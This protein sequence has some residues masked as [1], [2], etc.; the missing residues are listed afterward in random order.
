MTI[1]R[2]PYTCTATHGTACI[3]T[4]KTTFTEKVHI[5][6]KL[7]YVPQCGTSVHQLVTQIFTLFFAFQKK[8]YNFSEI[9]IRNFLIRSDQSDGQRDMCAC[10]RVNN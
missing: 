2:G 4:K 9:S 5:I 6:N 10:V 1:K 7:F 3:T 8:A